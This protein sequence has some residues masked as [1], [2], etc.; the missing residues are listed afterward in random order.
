[1]IC[2]LG[3]FSAKK[4]YCFISGSDLNV[5][6]NALLQRNNNDN[7]MRQIDFISVDQRKQKCFLVAIY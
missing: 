7:S 4:R 3:I 2:S 1:M 5:A 6:E